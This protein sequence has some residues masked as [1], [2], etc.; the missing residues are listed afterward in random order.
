MATFDYSPGE[1]LSLISTNPIKLSDAL[2]IRFVQFTGQMKK[3][4]LI[5]LT[6]LDEVRET[7]RLPFPERLDRS[8]NL[9]SDIIG[10]AKSNLLFVTGSLVPPL[11][12]GISRDAQHTA[13]MRLIQTA[14]AIERYRIDRGTP[15]RSLDDLTAGYLKN[16]PLDPF[17]GQRLRYFPSDQGYLLY[18][19]GPDR[20][21]D[22]GRKSVNLYSNQP[23]PEGDL[24]LSVRR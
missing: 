21:D 13:R 9:S 6:R 1:F 3:D 12:R 23:K 15:P 7:A 16:I 17:D 20:M 11:I 4:E 22:E 24:T 19:I 5:L 10:E 2:A 8:D 18:S 14:L